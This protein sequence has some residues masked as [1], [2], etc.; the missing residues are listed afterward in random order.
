MKKII[1]IM[2][3]LLV[4]PIQVLAYSKNE[5]LED[6]KSINNTYVS[7]D[8]LVKNLT[9]NNNQ[10]TF[11]YDIEKLKNRYPNLDIDTTFN[12]KLTDNELVFE[13]GSG[14]I[15]NN[16]YIVEKENVSA[17]YLYL[18]LFNSLK[19]PYD[20]Y[21]YFSKETI[22]SRINNETSQDNTIILKD[23]TNYFN[24]IIKKDNNTFKYYYQYNYTNEY[25]I[26]NS[27]INYRETTE[28]E[29]PYTG[30]FK[31]IIGLMLMGV[32]ILLGYTITENEKKI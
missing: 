3:I 23:N 6:L 24:V 28:F 12:Y 9:I 17:Y 32:I 27:N 26:D 19:Q 13:A 5:L 22:I 29:N 31:M 4:L 10:I 11:N 25:V 30:N 14:T 7:D 16:K 2:L 20:E 21:N 18:M 8:V 1:F 15:S